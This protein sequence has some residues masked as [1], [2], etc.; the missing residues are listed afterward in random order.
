MP[1][2]PS[3]KTDGKSLDR[4]L[5]DIAVHKLVVSLVKNL[6]EAIDVFDKF[7][8]ALRQTC[9]II[10][11]TEE[12][13]GVC[14]RTPEQM[15]GKV[16]YDIAKKYN[17]KGAWLGELNYAVT[18]L[19]Q[20]IPKELVKA[21]LATSE[22]RYWYYAEVVGYLGALSFHYQSIRDTN[23]VDQGMAG[24][25]TDIKDEYKRRVNV[26]YEAAQIIKS[27]DCY[28]APYYTKLIEI[29]DQFGQVVGHQEV[30]LKRSSS[31]LNKD[32][33]GRIKIERTI[34]E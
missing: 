3:K 14:I 33:V 8:R 6:K 1:Y 27:G 10:N 15:L 18:R 25:F 29:V 16:I 4:E 13:Y 2:V 19:I 17:Y 22:L 32:V 21:G 24:V 12:G 28:D 30:M 34:D 20:E 26:S 31:T 9:S 5:I 23:W 11:A 7:Y